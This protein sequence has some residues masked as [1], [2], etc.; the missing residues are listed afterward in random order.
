MKLSITTQVSNQFLKEYKKADVGSQVPHSRKTT[1]WLQ[2][3]ETPLV[4]SSALITIISQDDNAVN[5]H[6]TQNTDSVT[7]IKYDHLYDEEKVSKE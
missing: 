6:S 5:I 3:S 4:S 1:P 7:G 2:T